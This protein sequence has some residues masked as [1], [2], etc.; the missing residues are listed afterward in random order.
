[1]VPGLAGAGIGTA[2]AP[3]LSED[4]LAA[5]FVAVHGA[6]F[7]H[8]GVWGA[9]MHWTGTHWQRDETGAA[10]EAV[11]QICRAAAAGQD[12]PSL[13][14]RIASA[15]TIRSVLSIAAADPALTARAA[16]WDAQ[17]MLLNTP[18]GVVDLATGE[19]RTHDPSL[20]LT[21]ITGASPGE[22]CLL[23][24]QFLDEIT[25]GDR[26]LQAY[27][28]RLAGYCLTGSTQEQVFAFLHG[29]GAN[30]KS[31]F[32]DILATVLGDYAA[33]APL[34]SFMASAQDRHPTDLAGLRAAR[35][36][37]VTE[38]EPARA[39]AETRIK[40]VTG[41][42]AIRAR[43]MN[44]DFF[45]FRPQFKLIV[46][47]NHRPALANVGEAMRRRLHLV[48]FAVTI[49]PERRDPRLAEM[50]RRERDGILGWM[51][52]GCAE[53][54]RIGLAP[55]ASVL[56]AAAE[57]LEGEDLVGQW[58]ADCCVSAA[59]FGASSA[60]LFRSWSAWAEAGGFVAGSAK[61]LGEALRARGF[62]ATKVGGARGWR[63]I[64]LRTD[65]AAEPQP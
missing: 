9:W 56:S 33:A 11:R 44:R 46:A 64:A 58:I 1:M 65:Q 25:A 40:T 43:F 4:A 10:S 62:I 39:W 32:L 27:L 15:R 2:W 51:L 52:A 20:L 55:P 36:V 41:G 59:Q 54:Q 49:P 22:N 45:E 18:T 24:R 3:P 42:D 50:L 38:T 48:P 5:A 8:V 34:E 57:Y 35:L 26:D 28:A 63:G 13:A 6:Q 12:H 31:V 16:D 47:G 21:Q 23:W 37:L 30:G 14:R 29:S 61:A 19:V 53:W 7:R 17:P 60:A